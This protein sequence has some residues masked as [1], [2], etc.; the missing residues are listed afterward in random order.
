MFQISRADILHADQETRLMP[1]VYKIPPTHMKVQNVLPT[2]VVYY[3]EI[4]PNRKAHRIRHKKNVGDRIDNALFRRRNTGHQF[5]KIPYAPKT[6]EKHFLLIY[7]CLNC[8]WLGPYV[9]LYFVPR[10]QDGIYLM[11]NSIR[12]PSR[13]EHSFPLSNIKNKP[14]RNNIQEY[15]HAQYFPN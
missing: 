8:W 14:K 13:A 4:P 10:F 5:T 6:A 7:Y 11:P 1:W 12:P 3:S 15:R 2:T 9:L